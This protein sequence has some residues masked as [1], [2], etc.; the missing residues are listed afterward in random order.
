MGNHTPAEAS[1]GKTAPD[2]VLETVEQAEQQDV[3]YTSRVFV[4]ALFPYRSSSDVVRQV[5]QGSTKITVIA[6]DGLPY[7]K[8]PRLVMAYVITKAVERAGQVGAGTLDP[9]EARRIPLGNS[10]NAFLRAIGLTTRGSGTVIARIREQVDRIAACSIRV[11]SLAKT[12]LSTRRAASPTVDISNYHELWLAPNPDQPAISGS[13]IELTEEFYDEINKAPIPIDI[14]VLKQLG[15]PRAMDIYTWLALKKFWLSKRNERSFTFTWETLAGHFSPTE[16][17]TWVQRR[18]FRT[19]IKK[20]VA[21]IAELWPEVGVEVTA[22]GLL[23]HQGPTPIP[24][25]PRRQLVQ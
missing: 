11:E 17:T 2:V 10:L 9:G 23:V 1:S 19:E 14:N 24:P 8:Y 13:F 16:L 25:K 7:G 15:K 6:T 18:D 5:Q 3:G 21:S 4:Q 22:E 12:A 20:C